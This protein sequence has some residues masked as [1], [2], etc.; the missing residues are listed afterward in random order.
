MQGANAGVKMIKLYLVVKNYSN[1]ISMSEFR[2]KF[3]TF[4]TEYN[5]SAIGKEKK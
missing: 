4:Q 1:E 3:R 5:F 2:K